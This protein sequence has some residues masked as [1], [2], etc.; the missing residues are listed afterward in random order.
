GGYEADL[1]AHPTH[2]P[3]RNESLNGLSNLRGTLALARTQDPHS[4][5]AQFFIN[6]KDNTRL[7]GRPGRAGYTV[8]GEVLEGLDVV[9]K[10]AAVPTETRG[11]HANVPITP[12]EILKARLETPRAAAR[13]R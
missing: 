9:D 2:A 10:I 8:F 6:L 11:I 13:A 5:T 12:V 1:T 7:D 3:I 4:A